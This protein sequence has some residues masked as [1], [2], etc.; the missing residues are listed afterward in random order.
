[1]EFWRSIENMAEKQKGLKS[2]WGLHVHYNKYNSEYE[3]HV[4]GYGQKNNIT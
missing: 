3:I 4:K 2:S 1:M